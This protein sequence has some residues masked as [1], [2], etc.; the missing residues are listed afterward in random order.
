MIMIVYGTTGELIKLAPV[1]ARLNQRRL[2]YLA[3]STQQQAAQIASMNAA[4]GLRPPDMLLANG[5]HG[6]D[7]ANLIEM[8]PWALRVALRFAQARRALRRRLAMRPGNHVLMVHGDTVTTVAGSLM[9]KALPVQLAHLEAG[10]RSHDW[11][12]PFPEELDRRIVGR[13]ADIH[14][15]P[16]QVE[17]AN[18]RRS[19]GDVVVTGANTVVDSLD[20]VPPGRAPAERV[21]RG[22]MP[23]GPYGV[24]SLHRNEL[25]SNATRLRDTLRVLVDSA[26]R[27]PFIFVDHPVT[28]AAVRRHGLDGALARPGVLRVERMGYLPFV[29][30][31]RESAYIFTDSGGLQEESYSLGIPCLV[32]RT[33]TERDVGVGL[34]CVVSRYDLNVAAAFLSDTGRWRM[35]RRPS[36]RIPLMSSSTISTGGVCGVPVSRARR[37]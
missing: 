15:A 33:V 2:E 1:I 28:V 6:R 23:V 13:L 19:H 10:L 21:L 26:E 31:V 5:H 32:H 12:N 27:I 11:R 4:F 36:C 20:L 18:L 17:V 22:R 37:R 24:V 7:L 30:L 8:P 29:A 35:G 9:A 16:T 14:Y 3:V 34:N 25:L